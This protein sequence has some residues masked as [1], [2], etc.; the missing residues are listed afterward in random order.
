MNI[1]YTMRVT[2]AERTPK[3]YAINGPITTVREKTAYQNGLSCRNDC[4]VRSSLLIGVWR[5]FEERG[6]FDGLRF[7]Q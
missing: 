1:E 6:E 7:I 2:S 3:I 4:T 5:R